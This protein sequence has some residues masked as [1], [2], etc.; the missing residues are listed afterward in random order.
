MQQELGEGGT[1][2]ERPFNDLLEWIH[3]EQKRQLTAGELRDMTDNEMFVRSDREPYSGMWFRKVD[4]DN[5]AAVVPLLAERLK[6]YLL[7]QAHDTPGAAHM[8]VQRTIRRLAMVYWKTLKEDVTRYVHT[9]IRCQRVKG[10]DRNVGLLNLWMVV[11]PFEAVHVDFVGPLVRTAKGNQ[12]VLVMVAR[13]SKLVVLRP[14]ESTGQ[15]YGAGDRGAL[16]R[17]LWNIK[18]DYL[19]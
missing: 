13:F 1:R 4:E 9:C 14:M 11:A 15:R 18:N 6:D 16:D 19:G 3:E 12:Y 5:Y 10:D 7:A 2:E 17:A 8:G